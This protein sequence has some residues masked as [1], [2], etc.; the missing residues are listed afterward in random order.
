MI[1]FSKYPV[2]AWQG[3]FLLDV[4]CRQWA[5]RESP[6]GDGRGGEGNTAFVLCAPF[7]PPAPPRVPTQPPRAPGAAVLPKAGILTCPESAILNCSN[8]QVRGWRV[9]KVSRL[10]CVS[11]SGASLVRFSGWLS[12]ERMRWSRC[13]PNR[14]RRSSRVHAASYPSAKNQA[15]QYPSTRVR[16]GCVQEQCA[17]INLPKKTAR[18]ITAIAQHLVSRKGNA[19][20]QKRCADERCVQACRGTSRHF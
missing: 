12:W 11:Q 18:F 20:V 4:D 9:D 15:A 6:M 1:N 10:A 8:L 3:P 7:P 17:S 5:G 13:F 16:G 19:V 2:L 14:K